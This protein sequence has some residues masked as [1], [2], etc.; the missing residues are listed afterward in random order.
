[1]ARDHVPCRPVADTVRA[2]Y[3]RA[4][5]GVKDRDGGFD[6]Q[7]MEPLAYGFG[8]SATLRPEAIAELAAT[9]EELGYDSFWLN[10]AGALQGARR[11]D[12]G[13]PDGPP[14]WQAV[15]AQHPVD[16]LAAAIDAT[17]T[18]TIGIGLAPIDVFPVAGLIDAVRARTWPANRGILGIAAG[19]TGA[20][21][22]VRM[23]AALRELRDARLP[24]RLGSGGRGPLVLRATGAAA[25][26]VCLAWLTPAGLVD[27][28]RE[29]GA[30]AVS[31]GRRV[32]PVFPYVR[33]GLGDG[34]EDR[35]RQEMAR[36]ARL[37]HHADNREALGKAE[38]IGAAVETPA[39]LPAALAPY[40]VEALPDGIQVRVRLVVRPVLA[41]AG[42]PAAWA[43]AA[44]AL[45]PRP[46][47]RP[48]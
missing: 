3:K 35:V 19:S 34:G 10:V 26:D 37:P 44:R 40:H 39:E 13:V 7:V 4:N 24:V 1:M 36:Y 32:P 48:S 25:D 41:A 16:M 23:R 22:A 15:G 20:K 42:D 29:I 5:E 21:C 31:A 38:L 8:A 14:E 28:L 46:G 27:A 30:G 12:S 45:A 43:A 18:L 11:P 6:R 17:S 47:P 33:V 9:C 2:Q